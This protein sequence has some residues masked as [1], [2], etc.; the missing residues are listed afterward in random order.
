MSLFLSVI[1]KWENPSFSSTSRTQ[2]NCH[3]TVWWRHYH[4]Q[5]RWEENAALS[6]LALV[7]PDLIRMIFLLDKAARV[8]PTG[9]AI[10]RMFMSWVLV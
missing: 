8:A 1:S 5:R 6:V 3:L 2:W 9:H 10:G 4:Q 7:S